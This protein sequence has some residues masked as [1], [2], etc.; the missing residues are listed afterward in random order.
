MLRTVCE[1]AMGLQVATQVLEV[2]LNQL[3][4]GCHAAVNCLQ[5]VGGYLAYVGYFCF[6]AGISLACGVE[7]SATLIA[8]MTTTHAC[9]QTAGGYVEVQSNSPLVCTTST[10]H[11]SLDSPSSC[12]VCFCIVSFEG[13]AAEAAPHRSAM[14]WW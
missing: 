10:E 1:A 12:K 7:A 4:S 8:L 9:C 11:L 5:V 6:A 3:V 2:G 14:R 13:C